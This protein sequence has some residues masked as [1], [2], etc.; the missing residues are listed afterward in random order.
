MES[1]H[2]AARLVIEQNMQQ[3]TAFSA[4]PDSP[5]QPVVERRRVARSD[6]GRVRRLLP[7]RRATLRH[8]P[9]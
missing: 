8:V 7:R 2:L 4:R 9:A 5:V 3:M 1:M 6:L